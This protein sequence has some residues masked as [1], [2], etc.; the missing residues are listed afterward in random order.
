MVKESFLEDISNLLNIGEITSIYSKEDMKIIEESMASK[1]SKPQS[2]LS[3]EQLYNLFVEEVRTYFHVALLMSPVG[4]EFRVRCRKFPALLNICTL[5]W[6][7]PWPQE[8]LQSVAE[9]K[10][11]IEELS[12]DLNDQTKM[13]LHRLLP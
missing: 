9:F 13:A 11:N 1:Y 10:L 4:D 12:D 2:P 3:S 7:S 5:D 8:A 6:F